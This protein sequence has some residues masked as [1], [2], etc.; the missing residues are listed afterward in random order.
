MFGDILV[1]KLLVL[2]EPPIVPTVLL[3]SQMVCINR[4][5]RISAFKRRVALACTY[6]H[7]LT[8]ALAFLIF[9]CIAFF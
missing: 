3:V 1:L 9:V 7:S 6:T 4:I 8:Q 5:K 2:I